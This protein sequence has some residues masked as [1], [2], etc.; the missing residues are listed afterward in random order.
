MEMPKFL[1]LAYT[2][3]LGFNLYIQNGQNQILRL[4]FLAKTEKKEPDL[5][6]HLK[7]PKNRQNIIKQCFSR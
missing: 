6:S 1:S 5:P 2:S 7:Q 4:L 3:S